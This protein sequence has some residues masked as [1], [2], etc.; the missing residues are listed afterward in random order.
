MAFLPRERIFLDFYT[1]RGHNVILIA[2]LIS[3]KILYVK[4]EQILFEL[5][6]YI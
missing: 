1:F 3:K 2:L 6:M 5:N 4:I